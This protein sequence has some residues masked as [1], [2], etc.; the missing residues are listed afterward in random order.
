MTT[1]EKILELFES[2]RDTYFS[3]EEL[4]QKLSTYQ[5]GMVLYIETLFCKWRPYDDMKWILG[6]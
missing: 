5:F 3:G 6:Y 1:K 4:A 2:N